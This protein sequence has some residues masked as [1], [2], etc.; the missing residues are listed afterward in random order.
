MKPGHERQI[1]PHAA[2]ERHRGMTVCVDETRYRHAISLSPPAHRHLTGFRDV[3]SLAVTNDSGALNHKVGGPVVHG[4]SVD[5]GCSHFE[6]RD[7]SFMCQST[8]PFRLRPESLLA[9]PRK[10]I[11]VRRLATPASVMIAVMR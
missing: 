10:R 9:Q 4:L 11:G 6:H 8:S 2:Q 5:D 3:F 1:V 7:R